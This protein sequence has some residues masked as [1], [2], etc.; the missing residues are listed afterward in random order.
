MSWPDTRSHQ[1]GEKQQTE[2]N[3]S[4]PFRG[5][6]SKLLDWKSWLKPVPKGFHRLS[7]KRGR[8]PALGR[9]LGSRSTECHRCCAKGETGT[10]D[11]VQEG[12]RRLLGKREKEEALALDPHNTG[13]AVQREGPPRLWDSVGAGVPPGR[14]VVSPFTWL[15]TRP[16][17]RESPPSLLLAAPPTD[18]PRGR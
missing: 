7:E 5:D 10:G 17:E 15:R 9:T 11:A 13:C 6:G 4:G 18:H 12:P 2:K 8:H 3:T 16:G 14:T 1:A